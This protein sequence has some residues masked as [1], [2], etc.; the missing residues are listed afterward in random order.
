MRED[1]GRRKEEET[2]GGGGDR[3]R[4]RRKGILERRDWET[5]RMSEKRLQLS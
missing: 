1:R 2:G 4:R 5:K 3:R